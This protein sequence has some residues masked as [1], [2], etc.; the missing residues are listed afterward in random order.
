MLNFTYISQFIEYY[1]RLTQER[2]SSI[3]NKDVKKNV[4]EKED[5]R[6]TKLEKKE[7]ALEKKNEGRKKHQNLK[8]KKVNPHNAYGNFL[9]NSRFKSSLGFML[10][11][12]C[13][14]ESCFVLSCLILFLAHLSRYEV[15][16]VVVHTVQTSSPLQPLG[17]S[18]PNFTWIILRKG[19]R[20][21][22]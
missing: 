12:L 8:M 16:V 7:A 4:K 3:D 22:V 15:V 1:T 21:F 9:S 5:R 18:K 14:T 19:K 2:C 13:L 11:A 10:L 17:Q 20:K 6:K